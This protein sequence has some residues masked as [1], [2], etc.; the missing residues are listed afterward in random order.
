MVSFIVLFNE[1]NYFESMKNASLPPGGENSLE[2]FSKILK[3]FSSPT[4]A[5]LIR[6]RFLLE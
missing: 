1:C 2:F 4:H 5:A 6:V 3:F